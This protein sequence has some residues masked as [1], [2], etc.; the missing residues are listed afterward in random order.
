ME[1]GV[2]RRVHINIQGPKKKK[3]EH[4]MWEMQ[5]ERDF[6]PPFSTLVSQRMQYDYIGEYQHDNTHCT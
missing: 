3:K 2:A 1:K 4:K 5:V 6:S